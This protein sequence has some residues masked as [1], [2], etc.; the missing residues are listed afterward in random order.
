MS[1]LREFKNLFDAR[2]EIVPTSLT[3][4]KRTSP[5]LRAVARLRLKLNQSN[6]RSVSLWGYLLSHGIEL[7]VAY[8]RAAQRYG[9]GA[10]T[11]RAF[12]KKGG[13]SCRRK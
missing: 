13:N 10:H 7:E 5:R 1:P 12:G 9:V 8:K 3:S 6:K 2:H 11:V 4:R